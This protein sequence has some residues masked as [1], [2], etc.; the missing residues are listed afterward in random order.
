M[1]T[2]TTYILLL[3]EK[4]MG[5]FILIKYSL[6]SYEMLCSFKFRAELSC[7]WANLCRAKCHTSG[8]ASKWRLVRLNQDLLTNPV[9]KHF[10]LKCS[11]HLN[12]GCSCPLSIFFYLI[13]NHMYVKRLFA[14][15]KTSPSMRTY[16]RPVNFSAYPAAFP[17]GF[18]DDNDI[19]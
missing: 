11:Y 5:K 14:N 3:L 10:A 12:A 15:K 13:Y 1:I 6:Y 2:S 4:I 16:S 17:L 9:L 8:V 19:G 18:S 7:S